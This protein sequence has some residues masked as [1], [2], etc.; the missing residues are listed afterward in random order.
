MCGIYVSAQFTSSQNDTD[1]ASVSLELRRVNAARGPDAQNTHLLSF[2][3]PPQTWE[4][5]DAAWCSTDNGP[6]L[7]LDIAFYAS[8]LR[9]RG[10]FPIVQ[11]HARDGNV[12][13]WNGEVFEGIEISS[14]EN[15]GSKLF[16]V[17]CLAETAEN[18]RDAFST[19][20]GPYAFAFYHATSHRLYFGRDPLGRRSLLIHKPTTSRPYLLLSSV[21]AGANPAY[22]FV[23]LSTEHIYSLDLVS[24]RKA[25]D[26]SA[27]FDIS[28]ELIARTSTTPSL[29]HKFDKP[30]K[31][32]T[33]I[34]SDN[35]PL[36]D[37]LDKIPEYLSRAVD[38]LISQL[39]RSV[40]LQVRDIPRFSL[41]E[42]KA[43][44]AVLFSGGIDSTIITFL[45]NRH[46]P[47]DE[48]ID[49]LN[50]AFENPRK[51]R[52]QKEGNIGGIPKRIR[53]AESRRLVEKVEEEKIPYLV[54]DRMTGMQEVEELRRICPGRIWNFV[55]VNVPYAECQAARPIVESL[56]Y[57]GRTVMDLSLAL[58]LYFASRGQGQIRK[59]PDSEPEI[60][61]SEA[62]VLLNGLGSDE[63][64]G[65]YGRHRTVYNSGG[66]A[67]TITELQEEIDRIP[68]RNL[69][70][71]DRVISSHGKETRHPFLSL[72][73]VSFLASLPVHFKMDP[74]AEVGLGDKMLL[75]FAARKLG[76]T[77][78]SS[79]KKRAMQFGSHSARMD[80][81]RRGDVDLE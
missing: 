3:A 73:L 69:G 27:G 15:D 65:G 18:I 59:T 34:T 68:T 67:A 72:S 6:S 66:W 51:I 14:H 81:E 58:A 31:V 63:L 9:L 44:L 16:D 38:D 75:R 55:E 4:A 13:C 25:S 33:M 64:L 28:L 56:M 78:A 22:D 23:E 11:P 45:A 52:I 12:L 36:V 80:G 1:F 30:G 42:G 71:D 77:E 46:I 74:R 19:I 48:P 62:R 76:L 79:R 47:L 54:P 21:S 26:I 7:T 41:P 61:V 5:S 2:S 20:E 50:V 10:D 17:L 24:L 32:N 53:K 8:E 40:M 70:R 43:R 57:P 37:T 29:L 49:L 35:I 39:D 60:Y